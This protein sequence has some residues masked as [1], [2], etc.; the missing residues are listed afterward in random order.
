M[1]PLEELP[2]SV[3]LSL[4]S[5]AEGSTFSNPFRCRR[6]YSPRNRLK[7][8]EKGTGDRTEREPF[9]L[10]GPSEELEGGGGERKK[11][12]GG[13]IPSHHLLFTPSRPT[14]FRAAPAGAASRG[15]SIIRPTSESPDVIIYTFAHTQIVIAVFKC[16]RP[17]LLFSESLLYVPNLHLLIPIYTRVYF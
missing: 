13:G 11:V 14:F 8:T 17:S 2:S 1:A 6:N 7:K 10:D 9:V 15:H 4:C 16:V 12:R 3:S 5:F